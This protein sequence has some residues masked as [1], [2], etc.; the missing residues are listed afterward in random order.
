[1][2]L[3]TIL[4]RLLPPAKQT[5][6]THETPTPK[7]THETHETTDTHNTHGDSL[8]ETP[9]K[10]A[11]DESNEEDEL[12]CNAHAH[13]RTQG[14]RLEG[15][16]IPPQTHYPP[17]PRATILQLCRCL[18]CRQWIA[19]RCEVVGWTAYVLRDA[20]PERMRKFWSDAGMVNP[21]GWH[22]L[23]PVRRAGPRQGQVDVDIWLR[24]GIIATASNSQNRVLWVPAAT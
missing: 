19:G 14:S 20:V 18:D 2:S 23:R 17:P 16:E 21:A 15:P 5:H 1:M 11:P 6:N 7:E 8:A 24:S 3:K 9:R 13:A 12:L 4:S 22:Y 10:Q